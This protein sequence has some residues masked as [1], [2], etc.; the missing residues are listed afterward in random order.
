AIP[1]CRASFSSYHY[2]LNANNQVITTTDNSRLRR[3]FTLQ[4]TMQFTG[5]GDPVQ[6]NLT[7]GVTNDPAAID[8]QLQRDS[9][10]SWAY[11][12][13]RP[14]RGNAALVEMSIVVY[15]RRVSYPMGQEAYYQNIRFDTTS[16]LV[17]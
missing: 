15:E 1:R 8:R 5:N 7:P 16:N 9:R 10:L 12:L 13:R 17:Q 4:D 2:D 11:M 3:W 14:N 6:L